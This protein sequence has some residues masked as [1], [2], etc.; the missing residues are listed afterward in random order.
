MAYKFFDKVYQD[1]DALV[2]GVMED[3]PEYTYSSD[4]TLDFIEAHA[5]DID[6]EPEPPKCWIC[7]EP[8]NS[9]TV[10]FLFK[11]GVCSWGCLEDA[12]YDYS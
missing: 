2:E 6:D 12:G 9:L 4:A 5:E 3:Y 7:E 8:L 1:W 10:P 11:K